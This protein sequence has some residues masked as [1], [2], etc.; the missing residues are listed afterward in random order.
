MAL[1]KRKLLETLEL[2]RLNRFR[3]MKTKYKKNNM[4]D[5]DGAN[6]TAKNRF[7]ILLTT[8]QCSLMQLLIQR[9]REGKGK[10]SS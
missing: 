2:M 9:E 4:I 5:F 8:F 3:I 10:M 6:G 1:K 7:R